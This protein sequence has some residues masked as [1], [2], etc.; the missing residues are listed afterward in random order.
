MPNEYK[1]QPLSA[2]SAGVF[3]VSAASTSRPAPAVKMY[4]P[5]LELSDALL[6]DIGKVMV[7]WSLQEWSLQQVLFDLTTGDPKTGRLSVGLPRANNAVERV[8]QLCE[9]KKIVLKTDTKA[10]KKEVHRL[11]KVRDQIGHGVWIVD[12][13]GGFCVVMYSG[14]WEPGNELAGSA[15]RITPQAKP[16][17][18]AMLTQLCTDI[19]ASIEVTYAL[20][21]EIQAALRT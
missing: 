9:A 20:R 11:E 7:R 15:K 17:D 1:Q 19:E 10:L 16:I 6:R 8:E 4:P 21:T 5:T 12:D 13:S 3:T 18:E 14:K 2:V